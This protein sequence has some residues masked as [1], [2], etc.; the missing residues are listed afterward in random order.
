M[1]KKLPVVTKELIEYLEG[2]CPDRSPS[3][4]TQDREIWFSA[5]K[6]DLIRHLRNLHEDQ[7]TTILKGD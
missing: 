6:V 3:L 4:S 7:H 2:I 1:T 5:G